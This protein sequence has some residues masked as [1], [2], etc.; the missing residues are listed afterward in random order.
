[1]IL[2]IKYKMRH[3]IYKCLILQ[4]KVTVMSSINPTKDLLADLIGYQRLP[5]N[6]LR[7]VSQLRDL[8]EK[9]MML[10]PVKRLSLNDC[11][12]HPFIQEK[13]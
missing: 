12:K 3:S 1:M 11:L 5:E 9:M 10:D 7:K 4:E 6:Q 8:L 13:I 2:S